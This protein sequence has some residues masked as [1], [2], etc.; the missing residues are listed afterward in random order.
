MPR[1]NTLVVPVILSTLFCSLPSW[2][3]GGCSYNGLHLSKAEMDATAVQIRV[4]PSPL[5]EAVRGK[6]NSYMESRGCTDLVVV[7][8]RLR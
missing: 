3:M 6:K 2:R 8:H 7:D 1:S 4:R 5:S